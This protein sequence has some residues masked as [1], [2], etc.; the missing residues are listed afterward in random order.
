MAAVRRAVENA[1]VRALAGA[2]TVAGGVALSSALYMRQKLN[3]D[4]PVFTAAAEQLTHSNAVRQRL[5][6]GALST[7][8]VVGGYIDIMGGTVELRIPLSTGSTK[9]YARVEAEAE[10]LV[11]DYKG[12][13][14]A[15]PTPPEK[16]VSTRWLLRHLELEPRHSG[17]SPLVLYSVD[18]CKPPSK[19][20]PSREKSA[21]PDALINLFPNVATVLSD[22]DSQKFFVCLALVLAGNGLAFAF[23]HNRARRYERAQQ[24]LELLR[25]PLRETEVRLRADAMR[26]AERSVEPKALQPGKNGGLF[27][28]QTPGEIVALAP[29]MSPRSQYDMLLRAKRRA[30][31]RWE[32]THVS[33]LNPQETSLVLTS[34]GPSSDSAG[35][36][37]LRISELIAQ[38]TSL[39]VDLG[40]P[41]Q[42]LSPEFGKLASSR[43][44]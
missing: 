37:Q 24:L 21:L 33:L 27:G 9:T 20:A 12:P 13:V 29:V 10:W 5:G 34:N 15:E 39:P 16:K 1:S 41:P 8:G 14:D 35:T 32:L 40:G 11:K 17:E 43:H 30:D 26:I 7:S 4:H 23:M 18:A 36:A 42:P 2:C 28:W 38:S 25:L 22:S 44:T 3:R 19:W 6:G 31:N